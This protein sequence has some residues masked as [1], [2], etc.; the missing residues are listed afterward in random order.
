MDEAE[1]GS[2]KGSCIPAESLAEWLS[3]NQVLSIAL[4]GNIDHVQY[5]ERIKGTHLLP[6]SNN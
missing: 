3:Q 5:T 1:S 4:E 2:L 6:L